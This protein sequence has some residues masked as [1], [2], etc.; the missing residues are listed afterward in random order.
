MNRIISLGL[1]LTL[2]ATTAQ[3][4]QPTQARRVARPSTAQPQPARPSSARPI[5]A[6]ASADRRSAQAN[7]SPA[8][9]TTAST[10][11]Q[12]ARY[13]ETEVAVGTSARNAAPSKVVQASAMQ[14]DEVIYDDYGPSPMASG[15]VM[16][17]GGYGDYGNVGSVG[18]DSCGGGSCNGTCGSC[19]L[20]ARGFCGLDIC[21]PPAAGRQLCICLP[22]HYWVQADYLGWYGKGMDVPPLVT[23]SALADQG[24]L[25]RASTS[26]LLGNDILNENF[27][28][29]RIRFGWWFANNP[30]LGLELEYFDTGT[31]NYSFS[32]TSDGT[33]AL[34][35][36]LFDVTMGQ[37]VSQLIS[38]QPTI[39]GS[40][41]VA[42]S[43]QL[44]GG[45]VRFR[46]SLCCGTGCK[47][48]L[49]GCQ[50]IQTQS[51]TD[52]T[53]GY[54]TLQLDER[55]TINEDVTRA[56]DRVL[57][58]DSF[59]TTNQFHGADFGFMWQARRGYWTLDTL[60]RTAFGN[61]HQE[62]NI[63]GS[64][65][66]NPPATSV[67]G[68]V[69]ALASNIGNFSRDQFAVV[70]EIGATVGYQL[71][72]RLRFTVGYTMIYYS[73]VVRPGEQIDRSINP[74]LLPPGRAAV[75]GDRPQFRFDTTDYYI[76][77][78]NVGLAYRW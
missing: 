56:G 30:S 51:R 8:R 37:E 18:C 46:K 27:D 78:V 43:S 24:I 66:F 4:Q 63:S 42:A 53:L 48:S 41:N 62:V 65:T 55:L 40:I 31:Q 75:A 71:T 22:A 2:L 73:N 29:G 25:G 67:N 70:P 47:L 39:N 3:A 69:L 34:A 57:V 36:P 14:P 74:N 15:D 64:T 6:Q 49:L 17:D 77:G 38:Q 23:R 50:P 7:Q 20:G 16:Y 19:S 33:N 28:G 1:I 35:R 45:G 76:Q 9:R 61:N 60:L 13:S 58:T 72:E 5:A 32:A 52:A 10:P 44:Q 12:N 26:S 54:R 11:V 21:N 68:G 59:R